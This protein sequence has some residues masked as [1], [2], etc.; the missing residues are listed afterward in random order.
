MTDEIQP[1]SGA[2]AD[3]A[4]RAEAQAALDR[5]DAE[6]LRNAPRWTYMEALA[7]IGLRDAES[8]T[9]LLASHASLF[10]PGSNVAWLTLMVR[11]H[12]K[13]VHTSPLDALLAALKADKVKARGVP[14]GGV[15]TQAIPPEEWDTLDFADLPATGWADD[16]VTDWQGGAG[17]WC[18]VWSKLRFDRVS[19]MRAFPRLGPKDASAASETHA[20]K[21]LEAL[22]KAH[23][24]S[25]TPA[26][27]RAI[28]EETCG[29]GPRASARVWEAV[30]K[31]YPAIRSRAKPRRRRER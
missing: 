29:L 21:A 23:V 10:G 14:K 15:N 1:P 28:W 11:G 17:G 6:E 2:L 8:V 24:D 26:P 27:V 16:Y 30:A 5:A 12:P 20:R 3:K 25:G 7:W 4:E 13:P 31:G 18:M 22:A 19:V 9:K